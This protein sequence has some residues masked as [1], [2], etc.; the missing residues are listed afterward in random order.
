MAKKTASAER[1][2]PQRLV[3]RLIREESSG[4]H[5]QHS[6]KGSTNR[7]G[8]RL[9]DGISSRKQCLADSLFSKI[10]TKQEL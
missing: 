5:E 7:G 2:V 9:K 4:G 8:D 1:V 3:E 10:S 6:C